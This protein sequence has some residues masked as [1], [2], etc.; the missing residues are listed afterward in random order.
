MKKFNNYAAAELYLLHKVIANPDFVTATTYEIF[1][2]GFV[3]KNPDENTNNRSNYDY[4]EKF[5]QW[6][7]TGKKELSSELTE[8][9][10]WVTRFVDNTGLPANFSASYGWKIQEQLTKVFQELGTHKGSRR[11]YLQILRPDDNIIRETKTTHE[12][13]CTIGL[14]FFI[15]KGAL[16]LMVNMRSNNLYSVMPYDV[17]NFTSLQIHIAEIL[18][19]P[20][21]HY[22][23]SINSAHVFK[24]DARRFLAQQDSHITV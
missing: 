23:H 15:R 2:E 9:N 20:I 11:A 6:L 3:L 10:P 1:G 14:H 12:Y 24:G 22:Y 19:L 7:L 16:H 17:Y 5:F 13:P 8:A 21:G 18:G 4:A